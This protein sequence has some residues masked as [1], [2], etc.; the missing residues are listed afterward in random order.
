MGRKSNSLFIGKQHLSIDGANVKHPALIE[1]WGM[2]NVGKI[3]PT[4]INLL[5]LDIETNSETGD[6]MLLGE[7]NDGR[8]THTTEKFLERLFALVRY[9]YDKE[10]ALAYWSRLDPFIL[11]R[12][13]L[14]QLEDDHDIHIALDRYGQVG[15]HWDKKEGKFDVRP[16]VSVA[17][18][19]YH[20][21]ILNV[22]RSATQ[23]FYMRKDDEAPKKLWAY[24]IK[25]MYQSHLEKEAKSRFTWYSKIALE[26]HIVDWERFRWDENY[27]DMVLE[28]NKLDARAAAELGRVVQEDFYKAFK[29]YPR[30]LISK[31]SLVRAAVTAV[32]W[33][34]HALTCDD[35]KEIQKLVTADLKS[36]GMIHYEEGWINSYGKD[37]VKELYAMTSEA[38]SGG[39]IEAFGY[40]Y[41]KE[42]W[43]VDLASAYP[44]VIVTLK[45]LRGATLIKGNGEPKK[46]KDAYTFIRGTI[47]IPNEMDFSPITIRHP[48]FPTTNVRPVGTFKG[49]YIIEEREFLKE[50]GAIFQDEEWIEIQ[51][52]GKLS[53]LAEAVQEFV[54][55]RKY[56]DSIGDSAAYMAKDSANSGYG[57]TLECVP[58]HEDAI[59]TKTIEEKVEDTYYKDHLKGYQK[60][61]CFDGLESE[62]KYYL[63]QKSYTKIRSMWHHKNGIPPDVISEELKEIGIDLGETDGAQIILK[64]D[65]L[66][67][68]S[69]YVKG[70]STYKDIT[71]VAKGY[72]GGEFL[73]FIYAAY[74][75]GMVRVQMNHALQKIKEAGGKPI[76]TMTDSIYYIGN[77]EM[78]PNELWKKEKTL[79]YF[80]EPKKATD[81]ICL[82]S[83]R[84]GYTNEEGYVETKRRGLNAVDFKDENGIVVDQLD[85]MTACKKAAKDNTKNLEIDV[86]V[87]IS[88]GMIRS[89]KHLTYRDLGRIV[90]QKRDVELTV[91]H[92]K[93]LCH[94]EEITPQALL[95]K[96]IWTKSFK[97]EPNMF[98]KNEVF[99]GTYPHLRELM[100]EKE[101]VT[102]L[103]NT[104]NKTKGRAK[105]YYEKHDVAKDMK[106]RYKMLVEAGIPPAEARSLRKA[107]MERVRQALSEREFIL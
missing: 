89:S 81:L 9:A 93:R 80:E 4:P 90:K 97:I 5:G 45:D 107:S 26:A 53:V 39:D 3:S 66:Y 106:E 99:D 11:F 19:D 51:T 59:V 67:R 41:A 27:H 52:K 17:I 10:K 6:M 16:V 36:I 7:W 62:L 72:R 100:N 1:T 8:Y 70:T 49:S 79:G 40:G 46:S 2:V 87:L 21:G 54:D 24:D 44:G 83:G 25:G 33:N 95:S 30:T 57:I 34:K 35:E 76:L 92:T 96:M 103:E 68:E 63:D 42:A 84:Y 29:W 78:L 74:I 37:F 38:Y 47:I 91:G 32:T 64:I 58:T 102:K 61:I 43:Y 71:V 12:L 56:F 75:T 14:E 86:R 65:Q 55:L 101:L 82:G 22:I 94:T 18:G 15:G 104:R 48:M 88:P 69:K 85:W 73:N 20:F 50:H 77:K 98:G 23:F 28:S 60:H 105:T 13:F 31:G